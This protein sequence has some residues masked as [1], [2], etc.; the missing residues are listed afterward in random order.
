MEL[1]NKKNLP[2]YIFDW[3]KTDNYDYNTDPLVLSTTSIMRPIRVQLLTARHA[4]KS[5]VDAIDLIASR[6]G[7][8][9]HD[10]LERIKTPGYTKEQRVSKTLSVNNKEY[11]VTGKYDVLEQVEENRFRL[12]DIKTTSVWSYIH[13]KKD[14]IYEE[15]LSI[16]RWLLTKENVEVLDTAYIDFFFTDWQNQKAKTEAD[17]PN[18]RVQHSYKVNLWPIE[19]TE[20]HV[21]KRLQLLE[22]FLEVEDNRLPE[23]TPEELWAQSDVYAIYKKDNK[24]ATK[25]CDTKAEAQAYMV[26]KGLKDSYIQFRPGK[27]RRCKYCVAAPFCN[28]F[29]Q[30]QNAGMI[31]TF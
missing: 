5:E 8:A 9:I 2:Q 7:N 10:S 30:L 1:T 26:D 12:R 31:E 11:T 24:K 16:Y 17:Y 4:S 20:T 22:E 13:G 3:L 27:V 29:K 15:Q 14:D 21:K 23:C 18:H 25:L 19:K 6:F 28:Q